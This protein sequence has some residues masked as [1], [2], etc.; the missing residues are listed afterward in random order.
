MSEIGRLT[1]AF[2]LLPLG[3]WALMGPAGDLAPRGLGVSPHAGVLDLPGIG[4]ACGLREVG[5]G[6]EL[7]RGR[8]AMTAAQSPAEVLRAA[9]ALL[10]EREASATSAEWWTPEAC[11]GPS[12]T[13]ADAHWAAMVNPGLAEPLAALFEAEAENAAARVELHPALTPQR[14]VAVARV[15][16]GGGAR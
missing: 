7:P 8:C 1:Q 6:T 2:L 16:L 4:V 11:T 9:A 15:I 13:W 3:A 12:H 10:R 14:S 5:R